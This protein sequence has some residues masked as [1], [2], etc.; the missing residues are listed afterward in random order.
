M[1]NLA[2]ELHRQGHEL[3]LLC[4]NTLKHFVRESELP[5]LFS[6]LASFKA[7]GID[8]DI[9]QKEAF[10][11]LFKKESYHIVRFYSTVFERELVN[12]L[13]KHAFDII[14]IE[15]LHMSLYLDTIRQ[16]SAARVVLRS[17]NVE[18]LIWKRLYENEPNPLRRWYIR[19]LTKKLKRFELSMLNRYDAIVP[20]TG[21]D[22]ETFRSLGCTL[23]LHVSPTGL[24]TE[25]YKPDNVGREPNSV[26]HLGALDW[27]P[28]QQ[29]VSWFVK[30]IWPMIHREAPGARFYLAGRNMPDWI[31]SLSVP[32]VHIVGEVDDAYRFM[33]SKAVMVSP[34]LSGSGM[35]IKIIEGMAMAKPIVSTSIGAEGIDCTHGENIFIADEP[36]AF[37]KQVVF[38]LNNPAEIDRAGQAARRLAEQ[39]YDNAKIVRDLSGFYLEIM[40]AR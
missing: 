5:P 1:L 20:I 28:N 38:L 29:A 33:N 27:M 30:E 32:G 11:N 18:H 12:L 37:A 35:R 39:R 31:K 8:T 7:I 22:A 9:K 15:G 40:S 2:E 17:H 26:F 6:Q 10:R 19:I 24:N 3:H 13:K 21:K 36:A 16:N 25:K 34:L 4:L 14:Q 23:P